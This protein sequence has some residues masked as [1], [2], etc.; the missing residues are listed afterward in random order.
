MTAATPE[1]RM[2][3]IY[4]AHQSALLNTLLNWTY[5]DRHAAEDL[6]QETML[7]AWR[8]LDVLNSDPLAL[9][10]WLYTVARRI[11]IDR[12]RA[13]GTRPFETEAEPLEQLALVGEPFD[14]ILDREA[15]RGALAALSDLHRAALVQVYF[16]DQTVP[17]A[18][19]VL[20]IPEGTLKSRLHY[21][22]QAIRV[23]MDE[24][25]L[26]HTLQGSALIST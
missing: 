14:E 25:G 6:V 24:M 11:A 16:L 13:R 3:M 2:L 22:L 19:L 18:A 26:N 1:E 17:Q 5:G 10:P 8:N 7:R 4:E 12:Y 23:K 20:G 21:A 15:V 9:R